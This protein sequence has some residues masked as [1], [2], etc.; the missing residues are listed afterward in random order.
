MPF[1]IPASALPL[2]ASDRELINFARKTIDA[3]TDAGADQDGIHTM[4]AAVRAADGRMFAGV[5]IYHFTGGPCAE[6]VALGAARAAG[7]LQLTHLVAVGN[8]GRGVKNPCGKDRQILADYYPSIRVILDA[9]EGPFSVLAQDLL[10]L[11]F[12]HRAEQ[13]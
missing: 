4:G 7:A 3:T 12:D 10:P 6:L 9:P 11:A 5:N 2:T 8:H 13:V 1:N